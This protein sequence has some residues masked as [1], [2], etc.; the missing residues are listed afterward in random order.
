MAPLNLQ[1]TEP[2]ISKGPEFDLSVEK[3]N[4]LIASDATSRQSNNFGI[5]PAAG[6]MILF[7]HAHR[8]ESHEKSK[9]AFHIGCAIAGGIKIA[10]QK[11]GERDVSEHGASPNV[12]DKKGRQPIHLAAAGTRD[13][14]L[15]RLL[16]YGD[17]VHAKDHDFIQPVHLAAESGSF[18]S[19]ELLLSHGADV[20]A[21]DKNS[22]QPVHLAAKKR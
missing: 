4:E 5:R 6:D 17:D 8:E 12:I 15:K 7:W 3:C 19:L 1:P 11:F 18:E 13:G 9:A 2:A 22:I 10:L 16:S 21:E 14:L 20:H